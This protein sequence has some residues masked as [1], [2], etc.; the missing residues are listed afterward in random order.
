MTTAARPARLALQTGA[1]DDRRPPIT[2]AHDLWAAA[3]ELYLEQEHLDDVERATRHASRVGALCGSWPTR[4]DETDAGEALAVV[5]ALAAPYAT[6]E[7]VLA[8]LRDPGGDPAD[9]AVTGTDARVVASPQD[10]Q[11]PHLPRIYDPDSEQRAPVIAILDGPRSPAVA[12]LLETI[13]RRDPNLADAIVLGAVLEMLDLLDRLGLDARGAGRSNLADMFEHDRRLWH[14]RAETARAR[15]RLE[16][17]RYHWHTDNAPPG[18]I[19]AAHREA[20]HDVEVLLHP[21]PHG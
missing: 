20:Q 6:E 15:Q 2:P 8:A 14:E 11:R 13:K 4:A 18:C 3:Y 19:E 16:G 7:R 10:A 9:G 5:L 21:P 1:P 12:E 17:A